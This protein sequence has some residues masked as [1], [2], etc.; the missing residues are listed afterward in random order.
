M[1]KILSLLLALS[2]TLCLAACAGKTTQT[3]QTAQ[4]ISSAQSAVSS[5][6]AEAMVGGWERPASPVV[7]EEQKALLERANEVLAGAQYEALA[8]LGTQVV[9]GTNHRL[10]CSV[11]P[12][13]PD[14]VS[15]YAI[16]TLYEDLEGNVELTEVLES[17]EEVPQE[18]LD[19]GWTASESPELTDEARDAFEKATKDV[20]GT[21]YTPV[22]LLS[23]QVVAGTNYRILCEANPG[24]VEGGTEYDILVVYAD[25][26]GNA[27]LTDVMMF[28]AE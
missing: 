25:L 16:V 2:L 23:T 22:A 26:E 8:C 10:L 17:A 1:K 21:T 24:V 13:V 6:V 28:Q 19:G 5:A 15:T 9:A 12:T 27:E 7:T 3:T 14:A 18:G 11:T 4:E 20:E